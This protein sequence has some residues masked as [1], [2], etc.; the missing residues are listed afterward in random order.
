MLMMC[1]ESG[2]DLKVIE[3]LEELGAPG[4]TVC[5]QLKGMGSTGRK[6][7]NPIWPG[8]SVVVHACVDD[9][10]IPQIVERVREARDEYVKRPGC[11][12]FAVPVEKLL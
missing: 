6:H 8:H 5:E 9:T 2:L 4:Y 12:I 7:G 11:A 3:V 1:C 10:L